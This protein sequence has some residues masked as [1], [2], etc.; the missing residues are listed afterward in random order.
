MDIFA[1]ILIFTN[2]LIF[3]VFWDCKSVHIDKRRIDKTRSAIIDGLIYS[4]ASIFLFED[5]LCTL[6]VLVISIG[7]RGLLFDFFFNWVNGWRW[8]FCG[9]TSKIDQILDNIDGKDDE[10]CTLGIIIKLIVIGIGIILILI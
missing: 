2:L 9:T 8:N 10:R 7:A 4:I 1:Y 5:I 3:K 6:G